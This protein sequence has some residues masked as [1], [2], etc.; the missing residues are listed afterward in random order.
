METFFTL[1]VLMFAILASFI[2]GFWGFLAVFISGTIIQQI[3][4]KKGK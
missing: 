4:I 2:F 1:S 3:Q